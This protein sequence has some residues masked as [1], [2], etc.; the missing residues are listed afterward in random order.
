MYKES[1][2]A[3]VKVRKVL[4]GRSGSVMF[5]LVMVKLFI[6][7]VSEQCNILVYIKQYSETKKTSMKLLNYFTF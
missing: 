5:K 6:H 7:T 3:G 1:K 2:A 4:G